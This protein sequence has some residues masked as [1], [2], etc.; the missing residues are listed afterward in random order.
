MSDQP[1]INMPSGFEMRKL[2]QR[3]NTEWV[4]TYA[5][6]GKSSS[7]QYIF[8]KGSRSFNISNGL[9]LRGDVTITW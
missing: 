6:V 4:L 5:E 1:N 3:G 2:E 7:A 8:S 9:G